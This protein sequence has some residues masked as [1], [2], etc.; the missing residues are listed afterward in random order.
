MEAEMTYERL[1]GGDRVTVGHLGMGYWHWKEIHL[2]PL[3]WEKWN[4]SNLR[5]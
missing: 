2:G 3:G 4:S 5:S 1:G